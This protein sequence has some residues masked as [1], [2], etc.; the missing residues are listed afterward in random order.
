[1]I[2]SFMY[3][4]ALWMITLPMAMVNAARLFTLNNNIIFQ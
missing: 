3:L 2:P 4:G 1:L